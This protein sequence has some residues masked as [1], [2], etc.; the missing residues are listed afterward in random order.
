[1]TAPVAVTPS[2][3][4]GTWMPYLLACASTQP[5]MSCFSVE[6]MG[7]PAAQPGA[8]PSSP[9]QLY[10]TLVV[11]LVQLRLVLATSAHF[12]S[13][14]VIISDSVTFPL[15]QLANAVVDSPA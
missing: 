14:R 2:T 15:N 1:M 4:M 11:G 12:T 7:L 3:A 6:E 8:R 13:Y 9:G 5:V 10:A